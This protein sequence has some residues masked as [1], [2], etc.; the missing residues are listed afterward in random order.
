[1]FMWTVDKF[2]NPEHALK[3]YENFYGLSGLGS[4]LMLAIGAD[5]MVA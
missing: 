4:A 2:V 1:M 3:V 5:E